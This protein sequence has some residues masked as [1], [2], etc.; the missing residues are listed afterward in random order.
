MAAVVPNIY[1]LGHKSRAMLDRLAK[2]DL[3]FDETRNF[4]NFIEY[5]HSGIIH[6]KKKS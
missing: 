4:Q 2:L 6:L 5:L 1:D 3:Q